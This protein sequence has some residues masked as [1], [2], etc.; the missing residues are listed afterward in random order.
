MG[1][2]RR[3]WIP[4]LFLSVGSGT[5]ASAQEPEKGPFQ[6]QEPAKPGGVSP[7]DPSLVKIDEFRIH[8]GEQ[9]A[10]FRLSG[11]GSI[12]EIVNPFTIRKRGRFYGSLYEYH[13]NDNFDARNFFDPVGRQLPEF[14]RNQFGGSFGAFVSDRLTLFGTFDGL[15]INRGSTILSHVPTRDMKKGDF[16]ALSQQLMDPFTGAPFQDN[17][18]P[19]ERIHPVAA[20]ILPVIP[21]PNRNDPFRNFVNNLPEVENGNTFTGRVDYEFSEDSRFF[22]TY[23]LSDVNQVE[24]NDLPIFGSSTRERS[25]EISIDY[26]HDFSANLVGSLQLQ[27]SRD[28][29]QQLSMQAGQQGLLASLGIAGLSTLDSND[30][31]Y[32]SLDISGYAD[33]GGDSDW[34]NT[35]FRNSLEV[36][37]GLT[38]VRKKHNMEFGAEI[39]S[40]QVNNNR[41]GGTRRGSFEFSGSYSGDAFADFLLGLPNVAERGVGSDRADLRRKS[42]RLFARDDWKINPKFSLSLSLAYNYVPFYR[43]L[44]DNVATF[45]PLVFDPPMD[46]KIV[47][48]GSQEAGAS[49]LAGLEKGHAVYPDRNDWQPGIGVAYSPLGNNRLVIRSSYQIDYN[50]MDEWEALD[51][52][53]RNYP[54]F[55]TERAESPE[56]SP[57]LNLSS[58]FQA[59]TPAELNIRAIEPHLRNSYTQEWEL[60]IQNEFLR[61]WNVEVSYQGVKMTRGERTVVANVPFP[62][63]GH[64]QSRRPNPNFGRFSI[65]TSGSSASGNSLSLNVEKRVSKGFSLQSSYTWNRTFSDEYW[66]DPSNPRDL[67]AERAPDGED[68]DQRL[69]VNYILDLPLG[70]EQAFPLAWMGRL[71]GLFEGWRI[72]GITTFA[73]GGRFNPTLAGDPNNDG[74]WDDR[75]DRLGS[76]L[77]DASQRSIDRWF[78]TGDFAPARQ[79]YGFGNGGRNILRSPGLRNWDISFIKR[80]RVTDGGN[81]LEF[82][83]Q[84]FNAFNNVNFE[85]P[86]SVLGTSTFGK[87]FGAER[88]REI[89]IA[90]KYSF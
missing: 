51:F 74:V 52:I 30:E 16:G 64:L 69:S 89:E 6:T 62:G 26:T 29:E 85:E 5:L 32:P 58:P 61:N 46:G 77:L 12:T 76:G 72:S 66:D 9:A 78:A 86:N 44:H 22:V 41:T 33:L 53:G 39:G 2:P 1:V 40:D 47:V 19:L 73:A 35:S 36:N 21:D 23:S 68:S 17:Q 67:R 63:P 4:V 71:R 54:F 90:I 43:S 84:L 42:W 7:T 59:A 11:S 45:A 3:L 70:R 8:L 34:P 82:R 49:G 10:G 20:R 81:L 83:V 14:K 75:P 37:L 50:P 55:Y 31:G 79:Q 48:T 56:D 60:S 28:T 65:L 15:R 57:V 88:A 13:R 24:V 18:I 38:Y 25:Q 27:F 80:T 87:I